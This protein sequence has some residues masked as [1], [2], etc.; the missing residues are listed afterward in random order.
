M[1]EGN[2]MKKLTGSALWFIEPLVGLNMPV[3]QLLL[4]KGI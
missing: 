3:I 1:K 2:Q 4:I